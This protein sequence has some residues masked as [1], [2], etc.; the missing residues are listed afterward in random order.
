[1][2]ADREADTIKKEDANMSRIS[3]DSGSISFKVIFV[4]LL[5]FIVIH[6]GVKVIPIYIT[7][8][9]MKDEM[10]TKARFAQTV[11]DEEIVTGLA[12][13]AKE[14]GL[15]LEAE[16]F[17][18][19]RDED[20]HRMKIGTAWD[21]TIYFFYDLYPPYTTRTFHFRPIVEEDYTRKF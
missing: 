10:V 11:K 1:V 3:K 21:V 17:K 14:L 18:L 20:R 19:L 15:P 4:L 9:S 8:E 6:I 16:D 5:L 7:A 2:G 12:K 13:K